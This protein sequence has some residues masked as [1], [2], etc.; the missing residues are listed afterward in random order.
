MS[1]VLPDNMRSAQRQGEDWQAVYPPPAPQRNV[2]GPPWRL[3]LTGLVVVG[4]GLMCWNYLGPD[5]KRY[6]KISNM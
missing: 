3:L 1:S 5:I 4:V 2:G 6:I